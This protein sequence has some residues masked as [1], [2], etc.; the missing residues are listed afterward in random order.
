M[1]YNQAPDKNN[2]ST[3][4]PAKRR[5]CSQAL[6]AWEPE[7]ETWAE[8]TQPREQGGQG[9]LATLPAESFPDPHQAPW[10]LRKFSWDTGLVHT[11]A[12]LV[13]SWQTSS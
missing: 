4:G 10:L 7:A 2:G 12:S 8:D 1:N 9:G 6:I 13:N 11:A 5:L 3:G